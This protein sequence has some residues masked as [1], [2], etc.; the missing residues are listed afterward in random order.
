MSLGGLLR[1]VRQFGGIVSVLFTGAAAS[2]GLSFLAQFLLTRRLPVTDFGRL[3]ALLA[4]INFLTPIGSAGVNYFLLRAYGREGHGAARWVRPCMI[5]VASGT[6]LA[7]IVLL[8]YASRWIAPDAGGRTMMM[9]ACTPILLGQIAVDL[10]SV[11]FQLEGRFP[12]LSLWQCVTQVGRFAVAG[13]AMLVLASLPMVMLGYALVGVISVALGGALLLGF[14][15]GRLRLEGHPD[16]LAEPTLAEPIMAASRPSWL[17]AAP[18]VMPFALMTMFYVCYFQGPVAV[19]EWISGG[20]AAGVYNSA[21]L[22]IS[23]ISLIPTVIYMRLL[24]PRLCRWAE[25]ERAVF[26]SA[27]HVG[28]PAM[29]L[30]GTICMACVLLAAPRL[31]PLLFGAAYVAGVPALMILALS[32]PVR[33]VQTVFSSV[34]VSERDMMRKSGYLA[35]SALV[36]LTASVCLVP[37]AGPI[38]AAIATVLAET[39]LLVLHMIGIARFIPGISTADTFRIATFRSALGHLLRVQPNA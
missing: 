10:A 6:A 13:W 11:R 37:Y 2:A 35:G 19:L 9:V 32:I 4:V 12:L 17:E 27:F 8:A 23:A 21:F 39:V 29:A 36:G 3:A 5:L 26:T 7:C 34:F 20:T 31:L 22:V 33:F 24:M 14:W 18:N 30:I 38:G 25:H 28:V 16:R 1:P 15:Q